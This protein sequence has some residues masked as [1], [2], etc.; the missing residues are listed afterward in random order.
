[1]K[2][3]VQEFLESNK[4]EDLKT[5]FAIDIKRHKEFSNLVLL[6]YNQIESPMAE[7]IVQECRGLILD[8]GDNWKII[9]YTFS[10][11][12][13]EGEGHAA[14][15]DWNKSRVYEKLDGSLCQLYW[16]YGKW[17][18]ASSGLPDASGEVSGC[19]FTFQELFWRVWNQFSYQLPSDTNFCYSFELMTPFNKIVVQH[20]TNRLVLHGARNLITLQESIPEPIAMFNGWE[21]AKAYP[22]NNLEAVLKSCNEINPIEA[23][24]YVVVDDKFNRIKVKS[25]QY[26][27]LSHIRD[28]MSTRRMVEIVRSNENQE[29][30]SYFPEYLELFNT[31]K[32]RYDQ[33]VWELN[34]DYQAIKDIPIQK[35]FALKAVKS[36]CSGVLFSLRKGQVKS[37]REY[38]SQIPSKNLVEI[39]K[40]KEDNERLEN[41]NS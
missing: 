11:F 37:V 10:K 34:K 33:A 23:E 31:V 9:N 13:N 18:V 21:Y 8:E 25:P 41:I 28:C 5:K 4:L 29:F 2:L 1:M 12:F 6:K 15:I 17:H 30:L 20:K 35:D 14:K 36:L 19:K 16:Y 24:G 38:F 32:E 22:L 39:L 26:V 3:K 7:P 40:L 27:A